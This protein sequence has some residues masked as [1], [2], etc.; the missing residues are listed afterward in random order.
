MEHSPE[1]PV[2]VHGVSVAYGKKRVLWDIDVDIAVSAITGIIGP[3]GAGKSTL[4]KTII[5]LVPRASG[6]I[7]IFGRSFRESRHHI[8]YV[9]QKESVDWEYPVS[10]FDVVLMGRYAELGWFRRPGAADC[11]AAE[12]ALDKLGILNLRDRQ[13]SELSGGEQQRVFIARA[14]VQ[15]ASI[16]LMDE[17][18]AGVDA[19]TEQKIIE[20]LGEMRRDGKTIAIVH[21]DLQTAKRYFDNLIMLN[22]RLIAAGKT[23]EVFTEENL[24]KTYGGRLTILDRASHLLGLDS[25]RPL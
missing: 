25:S 14:L 9:P 10:A 2:A 19:Q 7:R 5:D 6:D 15:S 1:I 20:I 4:L 22:L 8:A 16:Y 23:A 18:L 3:N 24:Q 17:P 13:I 21:H 11:K 12:E